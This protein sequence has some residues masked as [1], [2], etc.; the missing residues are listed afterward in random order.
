MKSLK[1]KAIKEGE[2]S[3]NL[4]QYVQQQ[5]KLAEL[6]EGIGH[7]LERLESN[8]IQ[9]IQG[10]DFQTLTQGMSKNPVRGTN[11]QVKADLDI[12]KFSGVEPTP[13]DELT[14]EQWVYDVC[15][16]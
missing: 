7:Q 2:L 12:G 4:G 13:H 16:Y 6:I 10:R 9:N 1:L 3:K 14:F 11:F 5:S 8:S 15:A